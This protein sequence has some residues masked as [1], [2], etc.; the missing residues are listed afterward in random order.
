M[1]VKQ[2]KNSI[3]PRIRRKRRALERVPRQAYDFFVQ[4]TPIDKGNARRKTKFTKTGNLSVIDADYPYAV[5]LNKGHS[6]QAPKGMTEPTIKYIK[7]LINKIA[8]IV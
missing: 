4:T 3:G 8:R 1:K 6:K 7:R 2:V 5:P